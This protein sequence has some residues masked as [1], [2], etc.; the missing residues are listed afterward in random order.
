MIRSRASTTTL[1][2]LSALLLTTPAST[3]RAALP[4]GG[5]LAPPDELGPFAVGRTTFVVVDPS[6]DDRTLTVDAWYPVDA[7]D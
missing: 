1:L 3:V 5:A 7:D 2:V 4:A 6:R